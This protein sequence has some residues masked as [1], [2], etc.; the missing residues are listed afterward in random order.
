MLQLGVLVALVFAIVIAIFA[1]QN[2][3]PVAVTFLAFRADEVAVS[4]LVLVSAAL[5]AAAMLV[6]G[7]AREVRLQL[8]HR[9]LG[10]RLKLAENRVKEL[11]AASTSASQPSAV[12][13]PS[14]ST[15]TPGSSL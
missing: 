4:V 1:V 5:G 12:A 7:I 6:L 14:P 9:A 15:Q 13:E 3:T 8:R 11:E 2:T 10:Q